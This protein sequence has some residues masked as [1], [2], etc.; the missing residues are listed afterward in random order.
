MKNIELDEV[1]G[2]KMQ[3]LLPENY[4]NTNKNYPVIYMLDG[5]DMFCKSTASD[6]EW[7]ID[8]NISRLI[9]EKKIPEVIVVGIYSR[10]PNIRKIISFIDGKYRTL[11]NRKNRAIMGSSGGAS[12][13]LMLTIL[14]SDLISMAGA[15]S[16]PQFE[17]LYEF[18]EK[19]PKKDIKIWLDGGTKEGGRGFYM[20]GL[21][22]I[23]DILERKGYILG[24]DI[25][26]FEAK[27][28]DH[29]PEAWS[30]RVEYPYIF[31]FGK[32][33]KDI[34]DIDVEYYV[35]KAYGSY[36]QINPIIKWNN[37]LKYSLYNLADYKII[38]D[39]KAEIT[40]DG[41]LYFYGENKVEI[42]INYKGVKKKLKLNYEMFKKDIAS[43]INIFLDSTLLGQ[44]ANYGIKVK[45]INIREFKGIDF[46][47]INSA[48]KILK[49][50]NNKLEKKETDDKIRISEMNAGNNLIFNISKNE[51]VKNNRK[52]NNYEQK[53][54][55]EGEYYYFPLKFMEELID[56]SIVYHIES[57]NWHIFNKKNFEKEFKN[58]YIDNWWYKIKPIPRLT[59]SLKIFNFL[60]IVKILNNN[61]NYFN[62]ESELKEKYLRMLMSTKNSIEYYNVVNK[63]IEEVN[64]KAFISVYG[65]NFI[66]K[67]ELMNYI[68][69]KNLNYILKSNGETI[70]SL[71]EININA[72]NMEII[73]QEIDK[74]LKEHDIKGWKH[75]ED[76]EKYVK[77][78]YIDRN[79]NKKEMN[80]D[81]ENVRQEI[82]RGSNYY[83]LPDHSILTIIPEK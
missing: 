74:Y 10:F 38:G 6:G 15:I 66:Q 24:K 54:I 61:D 35:V 67:N 20:Y 42:E 76:E 26:Y 64:K 32:D 53:F 13:S 28:K 56:N 31:F 78:K 79:G 5:Q 43:G 63:F 47:S 27:D 70:L 11:A 73:K 62:I 52:L 68:Y 80:F 72:Q 45:N 65:S 71:N 34:A 30:E 44:K 48:Y 9:K 37:G 51:I 33:K 59:T 16:L 7:K 50:I 60:F 69:K 81:L 41:K 8:E 58:N 29:T 49:V 21:K 1:D 39:T 25:L 46:I 4:K 22:N 55:K 23:I 18:L 2:F 19:Q 14:N 17:G 82:S 75:L 57:S 77:L 12:S 40:N 3:I 36:I 83:V